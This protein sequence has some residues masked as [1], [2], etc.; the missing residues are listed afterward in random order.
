MRKGLP[1][2]LF[3]KWLSTHLISLAS[4]FVR[5][6]VQ[7]ILRRLDLLLK[8]SPDVVSRG[9]CGGLKNDVRVGYATLVFVHRSTCARC[10]R[11]LYKYIILFVVCYI[12]MSAKE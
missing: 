1:A 9:V 7:Y 12:F 11:I 2:V 3:P 8:Y 4:A 5:S 6:R 10:V